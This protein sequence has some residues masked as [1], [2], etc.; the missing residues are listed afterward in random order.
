[1]TAPTHI[2][3]AARRQKL[4][5]IA[6]FPEL[7]ED[8]QALWDTLDGINGAQDFIASLIRGSREDDA[9]ASGIKEYEAEL[10]ARRDRLERR[11]KARKDAAFEM[12]QA[13]GLRRLERPDFL[14]TVSARKPSV[15]ITDETAI[16][17]FLMSTKV[18]PNKERIAAELR[19]GH[20]VPGATLSNGGESLTVRKT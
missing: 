16:P 20:E 5:L 2:I 10:R 6:E 17:H 19:Q 1:M 11:A 18:Y 8:E 7:A 9:M 3:E 13:L 14:L 15:I 4:S 12:M